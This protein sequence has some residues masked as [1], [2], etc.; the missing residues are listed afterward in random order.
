MKKN[1][2]VILFLLILLFVFFSS[3]KN[4]FGIYKDTLNASVYL[5]VKDPSQNVIAT[6]KLDSNDATAYDTMMVGINT[7]IDDAGGFPAAP[8]RANYNFLGWYK[9]DGTKANSSEPLLANVQYIA[10]WAKVV[11]KKVTSVNN[12]NTETCVGTQGCTT[13]GTGYSKNAPNNVITYGTI[14]GEN[15]PRAGDAFDCDV[16]YDDENVNYDQTDQYGKHIERFYFVREKV[17]QGSENTA[18][19]I[20]YTSFDGTHGRVDSQHDTGIG[21][22]HYDT[23]LGWLPTSSTWANPGLVSFGTSGDDEKITRF[24]SVDDLQSVCGPLDSNGE[25]DKTYLTNCFNKNDEP[26]WFMFENSRFQSSRLGRAGIWL[27][28]DG[29]KYYRIQTNSLAIDTYATGSNNENMARPVIEIPMSALDGYMP[30]ERYSINFNTHDGSAVNDVYRRYDGEEIGTLP[31][32]T[33]EHY[34][35]AGWYATYENGTYSN[36]VDATTVVHGDMTLHAKW[37]EN[38]TCTVTLNLNGG[39]GLASPVIVDIGE[40]YSPGTPTKDE[41]SFLGWFTDAELTIPY[42]DT[43]PI[44]TS[45]LILYAGWTSANYVALVENVGSFETLAEAIANVPTGSVKTRVTL[46]KNITLTDTITIPNNKWVE[47]DGGSFTIDGDDISIINNG[48]LDIISGTITST[49][50]A[51]N[52]IITNNSGATLNILGGTINAAGTEQISNSIIS[53]LSGATVNILGGTLNNNSSA[54]TKDHTIAANSG[55]FN[56]AGGSLNTYGASA[57]INHSGGTL[58]ISDG[59]INAHGTSKAQAIYITSGTVN[60]SGDAYIKNVSHSTTNSRAAIDNNGGTLNITGGTIVSEQY[61]AVETKKSGATTTIGT[62]DNVIN[63]ST[64]VLRGKA[65]GSNRTNGTVYIYDGIFECLDHTRAIAGTVNKPNGIDFTDSTIEVDEVTYN[66]TYL[67]APT[68]TVRFDANGGTVEGESY[69]DVVLDNGATI[70]SDMPDDPIKSDYYFDGWYSNDTKITNSSTVTSSMTA[71]AK[72]VQS[73][74]NATVPSTMSIEKNSSNNI[75]ITGTDIEN[76]TYLSSDTSVA[77]VNENGI[78]TAVEEGTT[79]ITITGSKSGATKTVTVTVTPLM[80]TVTFLNNDGQTQLYTREVEDESSL[81]QNMPNNPTDTNMV[82][83]AWYISGEGLVPFTS[84]TTV[85]GDISVVASWKEKVSYATLSKSPNPF[86]ILVGGTGQITLTAT[87]QGDTIEDYTFTSSNPN[88]ATVDANGQVTGVAIGNATITITGSLSG[89]I[90]SVPVTVD[91]LKHTVTFKDEDTTIT[92]IEVED[93]TTIDVLMPSNPTKTNYI[94]DG[95]FVNGNRQLPVTSAT[96]VTGDIIAIAG[97][98]PS[99]QLATIPSTLSV[100]VGGSETISVTGPNDME[101]YTFASNNSTIASVDASTGEVT[102]VAVGMATIT[103]TG[104]KSNSTKTVEVTV[105]LTHRVRFYDDVNGTLMKTISVADGDSIEDTQGESMPNNPTKTD[106]VFN[107]WVFDDGNSLTPFTSATEILGD[108]DVIASWKEKVSIAS[109]VPNTI[110]TTVGGSETITVSPSVPGEQVENYTFSSSASGTASVSN[111]GVVTGVALGN[112]TITITGDSGET[113]TVSVTVAEP[114]STHTVTF[115]LE[116]NSVEAYDTMTVN[117]NA[118]LGSLPASTPTKTDYV[119]AGWYT[120][121]DPNGDE[122]NEQVQITADVTFYAHW[123]KIICKKATALHSSSGTNIGTLPRNNVPAGGFA[124]DCDV[125]GNGVIDT[126]NNTGVNADSIERFYYLTTDEEGYAVLM[127]YNNTHQED[128]TLQY[129]CVGDSVNGGQ[130]YSSTP[131]TGPD[132]YELPT[133]SQWSNVS[134]HSTPRQLY[135]ENGT[136]AFGNNSTLSTASYSGKAARLATTQEIEAATGISVSSMT[137]ANSLIDYKYLFENSKVLPSADSTANNLTCRS[138]YWLETPKASGGNEWRMDGSTSSKYNLGY[139][140]GGSSSKSATRPVIEVP[141]KLIEGFD[142]ASTTKYTVTFKDGETTVATR[143]IEVG[144]TIGANMPSNPTKTNYLFD[145]WFIDGDRQLPVTSATQVSGTIVAIA[146]WTPNI[147]LATV[148]ATLS[149]AVGGTNTISVTGPNGMENYTF[150]SSDSNIASVNSTTGEV[151]GVAVGTTNIVITGARSNTTK[152]VEVTVSNAQDM[153]YTVTFLDTDLTTLYTRQVNNGSSLNELMPS[154][155]IKTNY[156]FNAWYIGGNSLAPFT[157]STQVTGD[158]TV[159]ASWRESIA[160]ATLPESPSTIMIGTNRPVTVTATGGGLV[161]DYTVSSSD[162][163]SIEVDGKQIYA[164]TL[165][166]VTITITGVESSV[167]RTITVEVV[168]SYNVTFDPDNGDSPTIIRVETGTTIAASGATLPN[169]PTKSGYVFDNW[170]LY[171]GNDVTTT[172]LDKNAAVTSEIT[173]KPRWASSD[174]VAAIGTEYFTTLSAAFNS[175]SIPS[176]V[177]T[178]VRIL[179]DISNPVGQTTVPSGKSVILNGGS[180]TVSSGTSTTKQLI[181]NQGTL[182]IISGTYTCSKDTLA[183]LENAPGAHLY[184]DGGVIDNTNNRA[185]IYND[186][187]VVISGGELSS[188][189]SIRGVV[190]NNGNGSSIAMSGGTVTQRATSTSDKG[191]GAVRIVANT[192]GTI[193]GGTIISNSTNS[194]AVYN[195]GTLVVGTKD[196][197]YSVT[198]PVIQGEKYGIDSTVLFSL[199]DGIVKGVNNSVNNFARI[200]EDNGGIETG[201]TRQEGTETIGGTTYNTLYYEMPIADEKYRINFNANGGTG[202]DSYIDFDLNEQIT[203]SDLP[204]PTKGIYT[205]D[206]WY[207]DSELNTAF[208][209]F[210]PTAAAEVTYYASWSYASSLVPVNHIVT[211]DAMTYFFNNV[212]SWASAD[213]QI[214]VNQDT[215]LSNDNHTAYISNMLTNFQN[216]SCSECES[217]ADDTAREKLNSCKSPSAGT[218]CDRPKGYD[219]GINDELNVYLFV[220]GAKSGSKLNGSSAGDYITV[221]NGVIYNMIPGKSYYWELASDSNVYGVVSATKNTTHYRRTLNTSVRNLRDLGGMSVSYTVDGNTTTGTIK[222]GR[223]YRGAQIGTNQAAINELKKLGITREVDLRKDGDNNTGHAKFEVANYDV[224]VNDSLFTRF[225]NSSYL[226]DGYKDVMITN[227]RINP[228]ANTY[229]TTAYEN[230]FKNLKQT[231]KAVMRQIVNHESIFFHCSIGTDRTGTIA[232]FLEGLLGA[233]EEDRL[234]D[235]DMTYYFGLTNRTRFHNTLS[236]SSINP[237]FYAMYKS[238]PTNADI[239]VFYKTFPESDDDSLLQAFRDEMIE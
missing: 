78:V 21:S 70:G 26:N 4:A 147:Q 228:V 205:F 178:E 18:V 187:A 169:N 157:A 44:S 115:K 55:E 129:T 62:D 237:R 53:N 150:T 13:A 173:Y 85:T 193:T 162:I 8:T 16:Y 110:T 38:S 230:D 184:I 220:N 156:F 88:F 56:I 7:S 140:N 176:G 211:S 201:S 107:G 214:A 222:Y 48:K 180:F 75:T 63:I 168:N 166:T 219:T 23:T 99:I 81:G 175:S 117:H 113:R 79:T 231:M 28:T 198:N 106:Y 183:T 96:E 114:S 119:F 97:W 118:A 225:V 130:I 164:M 238:Y 121:P 34:T 72:W 179:Q 152:T 218:Y 208:T 144:T 102:G 69:K 17:N 59:E 170:Y 232:Y 128:G 22:T 2:L 161:E 163:N 60:I 158:I 25:G 229:F 235:Y 36:P 68:V 217:P 167:S 109:I 204:T 213:A 98:T 6:F 188:S 123:D 3:N 82:F 80:H 65:Y 57:A 37:T 212:S 186:G 165:G 74:S 24:L 112:A 29:T 122:I 14:Y 126:F 42:D 20:Y 216:Y 35:F 39:T 51:A 174:K 189:S 160:I 77:T 125:N 54:G 92:S 191:P 111:S 64:P 5:S 94:F 197:A 142:A 40:N 33:R 32:T 227:Y 192:S 49:A 159:I 89:A 135:N 15:S 146:G 139:A 236:T 207:T 233:S 100:I 199:Y 52:N 116:E 131:T 41:S 50:T 73:I 91:V 76:V 148:P 182:R 132:G 9:Q 181:Y 172:P 202:I 61:V 1:K 87:N 234:R 31:T 12:L 84:S 177:A 105:T 185:A 27:E 226:T 223:L 138:N 141:T 93:G 30:A 239:E 200:D 210:T 45:T 133:T 224:S 203:A 108:I 47:L 127:F 145:G 104:S 67:L 171:D 154:N 195:A 10:H 95:W 124:Y 120:L 58:S 101:S 153:Q 151:T 196:N 43:V 71:T 134:L 46:L 206:G 209:T 66:S 137:A 136:T 194:G 103:I 215:D 155:P 11:C 83:A 149:V 19:L 86:E 90:V 221:T 190:M 143:E